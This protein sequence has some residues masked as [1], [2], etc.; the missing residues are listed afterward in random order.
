MSQDG[1]RTRKLCQSPM[2]I[3]AVTA[4]SFAAPVLDVY[5]SLPETFLLHEYNNVCNVRSVRIGHSGRHGR[6]AVI[7]LATMTDVDKALNEPRLI[8]KT[9]H[10]AEVDVMLAGEEIVE[11]K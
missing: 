5:R 8:T 2:P 7:Y 1:L 10:N 4:E 3:T 6:Y 9:Y 11:D